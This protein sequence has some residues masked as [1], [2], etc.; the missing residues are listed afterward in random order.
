MTKMTK[1]LSGLVWIFLVFCVPGLGFATPV[2]AVLEQNPPSAYGSGSITYESEG[3]SF[4]GSLTVDGLI[5]GMR[6]Q[7]KLD[8]QPS[9]DLTANNNIGSIGRWWVIDPS[10]PSGWGGRNATDD[11]VQS[12]RDAGYTVLGYILFDSFVYTGGPMSLDFYLDSSYHTDSNPQ[13][14]RPAPGE[15]IMPTGDYLVTFLLT[16]DS[17]PWGTPL[18]KQDISFTVAAPIPEPSTLILLGSALAGLGLFRRISKKS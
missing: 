3:P 9:D 8:G 14:G 11:N 15:V 16:E 17:A 13:P 1:F 5:V 10:D 12:E 2:A 7:M 6:Y 18:L 4:M